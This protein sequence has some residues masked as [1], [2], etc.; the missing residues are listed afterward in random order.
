M[1]WGRKSDVDIPDGY[2][3]TKDGETANTV[4]NGK[5]Y[6]RDEQH[7]GSD[8]SDDDGLFDKG[9]R[10]EKHYDSAFSPKE[11]MRNNAADALRSA[12]EG[13]SGG[14]RGGKDSSSA[15]IGGQ[16]SREESAS[17]NSHVNNVL[18]SKKFNDQ[19]QGVVGRASLLKRGG[20]AMAVLGILVAF[21]GGMFGSQSMMAISFVENISD[22]LDSIGVSTSKRQSRFI[23]MQLD[24]N[25]KN[26]VKSTLFGSKFKVTAKQETKLKKL[27]IDVEEVNGKTFLKY[28]G[29]Y[30]AASKSAAN[31][32]EGAV[33]FDTAFHQNSAFRH[34]YIEGSATWRTAVGAWFDKTTNKFLTSKNIIR[35]HSWG[36]NKKESDVV[37]GADADSSADRIRDTIEG[38]VGDGSIDGDGRLSKANGEVDGEGN[39]VVDSDGNQKYEY[40]DS[41]TS[42]LKLGK[43]DGAAGIKQKLDNFAQT[44]AAKAT[45]IASAAAN[46]I[47]SVMDAIGAIGLIVAAAETIQVVQLASSYLEG[48]QKGKIDDSKDAPIND[49]GNTLTHV[50]TESFPVSKV[51]GDF[52]NPVAEEERV[53]ITG[54]A[55]TS[56]SVSALYGGYTANAQ[57]P[58]VRS[59][60]IWGNIQ[61][62]IMGLGMSTTS[63]ATCIA[64]KSA[65]A[66]V[67]IV[68]DVIQLAV[69]LIPPFAGCASYIAEAAIGAAA[70]F[71]LSQ[72]IS[73]V[74]GMIVPFVATMVTRDLVNNLAGE[75][76]GNAIMSGASVYISSN[77]KLGGQAAASET[78]YIA[79]LNAHDSYLAEKAQ[80]ER[81]TKSPFDTSS[82][83]TFMGK[84]LLSFSHALTSQNSVM[85]L[86]GS[87]GSIV[88][89]SVSAI[90]PGASAA[91]NAMTAASIKERTAANCTYADS[92]NA[93]ADE[94]CNPIIITDLST[95]DEHPAD[96]I[97]IVDQLGDNFE[98]VSGETPEMPTIK[99]ESKL[100]DYIVY[101]GQRESMLGVADQNIAGAI[102]GGGGLG[103]DILGAVPIA[104]DMA[105]IFN[106]GTL[107]ANIGY[108]T[109][110]ACVTGNDSGVMSWIKEGR[111][112]QRFIEDQRLAESMG[113]VEKSSVTAFLEEYYEENPLDNSYEGVLARKTGLTKDEVIS[114]L[115]TIEYLTFI[116]NYEPDGLYPLHYE[117]PEQEEFKIENYDI[118]NPLANYDKTNRYIDN[119][120]VSYNISA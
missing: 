99:N 90:V 57:D 72:A 75:S 2:H 113:I 14:A 78:S 47:C 23:N 31:S 120:R 13:A 30:I 71:A 34:A 80:Y 73:F 18:G 79:Y 8:Y 107:A 91:E 94:F 116:A 12:D 61:K 38:D 64:T 97:D 66:A 81:E 42:G 15:S 58:S 74:V 24:E 101:C 111:Y 87:V 35:N 20:P 68:E 82:Q 43:N 44:K 22:S 48:I 110:E 95:I 114:T 98:P 119:R 60:N 102:Q 112:F 67:G 88:S 83:H 6:T 65:A 10:A 4:L 28:D 100:A 29:K 16:K 85:S 19:V 104:G 117:A 105:E 92:V 32:L 63:Y 7:H 39:P 21:A 93:L 50:A 33:D 118:V 26:C 103:A 54:S 27:G 45:G 86:V 89:S 17:Q 109:G 77:A 52:N 5:S 1:A 69:C 3:A 55:M 49:L 76:L 59:F 115:D 36:D 25:K 53:E 37:A 62:G 108:I 9:D 96:V 40:A 11:R 41:E 70:N 51:G 56:E 84:I 46:S 106:N